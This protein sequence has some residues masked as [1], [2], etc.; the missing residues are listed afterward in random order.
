V[1]RADERGFG[2]IG[3]SMVVLNPPFKLHATLA[4]VLPWLTDALGQYD[5]AH[6]LLEQRAA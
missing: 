1:Q 2:L 5:G 6:F 4:A 3:S